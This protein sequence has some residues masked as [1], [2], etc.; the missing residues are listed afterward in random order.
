[1]RGRLVNPRIL[2]LY[3]SPGALDR[4]RLD[5][6]HRRID[7]AIQQTGSS[8]AE[9]L[10]RHAVTVLDVTRELRGHRY[11]I[12]HFSGHGSSDGLYVDCPEGDAADLLT[13]AKLARIVADTQPN[14]AAIVL[15]SCYSAEL[16]HHFASSAPYI[17]SVYGEA[18]DDA[19]IEFVGLF[20]EEYLR[21]RSVIGAFTLA[22]NHV[23]DKLTIAL[24][25]KRQPQDDPH[26]LAIYPSRHRD[27]IFVDLSK[28]EP[29]I[30]RLEIPREK[31]LQT[32]SRKV[33]LHRWLFEGERERVVI[34]VGPYFAIFSWTNA[35]DL[36]FCHQVIRL[37]SQ[38]APDVH[39]VLADIIVSYNDLCL[40]E[41]RRL[42]RP[43]DDATC[44]VLKIGINMLHRVFDRF[45]KEVE[46]FQHLA[47][48][49]PEFMQQIRATCWANL[50][51]ADEKFLERDYRAAVIFAETAL[52]S[53]HDTVDELLA[54]VGD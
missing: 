27:P 2:V 37:R 23:D 8:P 45:F 52:S 50:R 39:H 25:K 18:D 22:Q 30:R 21:S 16:H 47:D 48:M 28:A 36:V 20:Y 1:M 26:L 6:E 19:A 34:P 7:Q 40:L 14:L 9:V 42:L 12:V 10:R 13:A 41:Y 5:R 46:N 11:E 3:S 29:S 53:F 44:S 17:V 24:F 49:A 54:A 38:L 33:R 51:K 4:L 35:Y 43:V 32:L 31:F 15:M